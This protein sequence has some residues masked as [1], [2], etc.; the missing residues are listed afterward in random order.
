MA[1][2]DILA[3]R[4]AGKFTQNTGGGSTTVAANATASVTQTNISA[5][6][7]SE[8]ASAIALGATNATA[9]VT[10]PQISATIVESEASGDVQCP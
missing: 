8:P 4:S 9:S 6:V 2:G 5:T 1:I 7:A 3:I 10:T